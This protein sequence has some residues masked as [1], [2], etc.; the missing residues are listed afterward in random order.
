MT[1]QPRRAPVTSPNNPFLGKSYASGLSELAVRFADRDALVFEGRRWSFRDA[2]REIDAISARLASLGLGRGEKISLWLPNRPEFVWYWLGAVQSGIVPVVLNNRMKPDEAAYQIDQSD[3]VAIVV[4][5]DG[6][7][8]DFLADVQALRDHGRL[9]KLKHVLVLDRAANMPADA[10]DWSQPAAGDLPIPELVTDPTAAGFIV[11]SSGTTALPKGA[12]LNQT[13]L[14]KAW[15][16]GERFGQT[17]DDRFLMVVPLFGIL[18]NV[19]GVLTAWSRGSCVV[20][21]AQFEAGR[22]IET[23]ERERCTVAYLFPV[24]IE[25]ILEH[26]AYRPDRTASLRTGILV[27]TDTVAM[28]RVAEDLRMPGYFTSYGMTET[29][30]AC[31]RCYSTDPVKIRQTTHGLPLPDIEVEIRD[32]ESGTRLA[33]R[34]EGEICVRGYNIMIEYY[35]KPVET[36]AATTSDGFFR[37]GDLGYMTEEGRLVFLR[38]IKDGY[39]HKGF[40]VSTAE[41]EKVICDHPDVAEAA[42]VGLPDKLAG[43]IGVAFVIARPGKAVE[44]ATIAAWLNPKLSSFKLPAH[45]FVVSEFPLTAGT[46]KVQKFKL[47]EMAIERLKA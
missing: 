32:V 12:V 14:R 20:L 38:R 5:G 7:F 18:A 34:A 10:A 2:K 43:D 46:G 33:P 47:R 29:S 30:S 19:N 24:M 9:P 16:H 40:N 13:G 37:T 25:R 6:A 35:N 26:P 45:V 36:A 11:Y 39:K 28:K 17:K 1:V 27:G 8:R 41:V 3:S 15:D 44:P 23:I 42:V 21:E 4:P 31:T 22:I